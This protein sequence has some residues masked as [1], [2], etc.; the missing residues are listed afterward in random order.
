MEI[1][2]DFFSGKGNYVV[3]AGFI[4]VILSFL[5]VVNLNDKEAVVEE[6][7]PWEEHL[8]EV[9]VAAE[10]VEDLDVSL[11]VDIKGEVVKP[12]VYGVQSGE[13]V[14]DAINKAGGFTEDANESSI[15][16]AERCYD[17]MVIYVPSFDEEDV[18]IM[19]TTLKGNQQEG[20]VINQASATELTA[21][22]GIGPAKAEAIV[23]YREENGPFQTVE[24]IIQVPGIGEKTLEAIRD[25]IW[26]K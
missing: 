17:E 8:Q 7:Q 10:N 6:D 23:A 2:K 24:E 18:N 12:G 14:H 21:L 19:E 25:E 22:P 3:F 1:M 20:I 16:L 11:V 4:V 13:R 15:N 9:S 5:L 26:L